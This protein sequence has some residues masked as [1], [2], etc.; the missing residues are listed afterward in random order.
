MSCRH[1]APREAFELHPS[2]GPGPRSAV[3]DRAAAT[4]QGGSPALGTDPFI[5]RSEWDVS[6]L[7]VDVKDTA[8]FKTVGTVTFINF[9]KP[10]RV[11]LELLRSGKEW[12]IADI[13]WD[14]GSL[15]RL[16]RRKTAY[17]GEAVR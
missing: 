14:S 12:R 11:V 13:V 7:S 16:Y 5:G 3:E 1:F 15:R 9:G 17:E 10:E 2:R 4:K 6:D 8:G